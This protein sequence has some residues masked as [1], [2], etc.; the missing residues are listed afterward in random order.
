[1]SIRKKWKDPTI[2]ECILDNLPMLIMWVLGAIIFSY[3]GWLAFLTYIVYCLFSIVWFVRYICTY[4]LNSRLGRCVGGLG[5]IAAALFVSNPPRL[6]RR[7]FAWNIAIL[8]PVWFV[9]AIVAIYILLIDFS[10]A[11]LVLLV[12]FSI[13]SFVIL[14]MASKKSTCDDCTMKNVCPWSKSHKDGARKHITVSSSRV[15][16]S[17]DE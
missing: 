11:M 2:G 7:Q 1:M 15:A 13:I 10:Y 9:P 12:T 8:F 4:C 3:F 5:N 6:F 16:A 17:S 14:P